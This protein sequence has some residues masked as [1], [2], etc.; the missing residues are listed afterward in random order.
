MPLQSKITIIY[1]GVYSICRSKAG[2][3][4]KGEKAVYY[5]KGLTLHVKW[6]IQRLTVVS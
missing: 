5:F 3:N 2:L 6:Y 1:C 4:R